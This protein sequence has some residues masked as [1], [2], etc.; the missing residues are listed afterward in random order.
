MYDI[1][2][3][4]EAK[5]PSGIYE[6]FMDLFIMFPLCAI[7]DGRYFAV[8]GGLSPGIKTIGI[9]ATIQ[10][11]SRKCKEPGKF[12]S[13]GHF[14]TCSGV[15]QSTKIMTHGTSIKIDHAHIFTVEFKH[16]DSSTRIHSK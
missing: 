10:M 6:N 5:Y 13:Q 16:K 2:Y 12:L 7:V 15:I 4:G 9:S 11:K 3:K 1:K 14:A 8:H